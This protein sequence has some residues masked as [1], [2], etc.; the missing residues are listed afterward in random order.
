MKEGD[1]PRS[2]DE[3]DYDDWEHE[4]I[5]EYMNRHKL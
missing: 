2:V 3:R 4:V 5:P 1:D